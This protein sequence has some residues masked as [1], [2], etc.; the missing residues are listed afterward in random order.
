MVG[1]R[2]RRSCTT[3]YDYKESHIQRQAAWPRG[4]ESIIKR[5]L[6]KD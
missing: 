5:A 6:I 1:A 3:K 2:I 4:K